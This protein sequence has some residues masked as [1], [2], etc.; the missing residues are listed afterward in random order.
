M[1]LKFKFKKSHLTNLRCASFVFLDLNLE[2]QCM[3]NYN[4]NLMLNAI[5]YLH[6][7]FHNQCY[8]SIIYLVVMRAYCAGARRR[9]IPINIELY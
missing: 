9:I 5:N 6:F 2:I 4:Y 3:N 1:L 7:V 8:F